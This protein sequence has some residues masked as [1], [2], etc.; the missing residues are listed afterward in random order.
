[1]ALTWSFTGEVY[2]ASGTAGNDVVTLATDGNP[3]TNQNVLKLLDGN[4]YAMLDWG[5]DFGNGGA[6]NDT[7]YGGWGNDQLIG[8]AD[9]DVLYGDDG[10]DKLF[11][12]DG[13]DA[14]YGGAGNDLLDSELADND[15]DNL[16]GGNGHDT[17]VIRDTRDVITGEAGFGTASSR[18]VIELYAA[19]FNMNQSVDTQAV[20]ELR[21]INSSGAK[22]TGNMY[23]NTITGAAG[24]DDINGDAGNDRI[25]GGKGHDTLSGSLGDDEVRGEDGSDLINGNNGLDTLTGGTG[26]DAMYGGDQSDWMDGGLGSDS[27]FGGAGNDTMYGEKDQQPDSTGFDGFYGGSGHDKIYAGLGN[28]M[29]WGD[30]GNDVLDGGT[31]NDTLTG[32]TGDDSYYVDSAQDSVRE[33]ANEGYDI[34]YASVSKLDVGGIYDP[35]GSAIEAVIYTGPKVAVEFWGGSWGEVFSGIAAASAV[36]HGRGGNDDITGS[37]GNDS[38]YGDDGNDFIQGLQGS[39]Y[40]DGGSGND[41]LRGGTGNDYYIIN[42]GDTVTEDANGGYDTAKVWAKG[43]YSLAANVEAGVAWGDQI[44]L[45]QGNALDNTLTASGYSGM[46]LRGLD[47][48]DKLIGTEAWDNLEGGSGNDTL[49][50]NGGEDVLDGGTGAD[51]MQ[52]GAG[53][54]IYWVDNAGDKVV[55]S[56]FGNGVDTVRATTSSY[57]LAADVENLVYFGTTNFTGTGS[58]IANRIEGGRANDVLKGMGGNDVIVGHGGKDSVWGGAGADQFVFSNDNGTKND[59]RVMDF[60]GGVDKLVLDADAGWTVQYVDADTTSFVSATG[61]TVVVDGLDLGDLGNSLIFV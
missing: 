11:G 15:W 21:I 24:F 58:D 37:A 20:E 44:K 59:A 40:I 49:T 25:L 1:M 8:E 17:Y 38:L 34:I 53:N 13:A 18:D 5:D 60:Q 57:T 2:S 41:T 14:M 42:P 31:G 52:G 3:L 6:G 47:G 45:L 30:A 61:G 43:G 7:I 22:V 54:D 29:V 10:N 4:D 35:A 36:I 28:D 50:G 16:S 23:A 55:E 9:N 32:G 56:I 12:G 27:L 48:Q 46:T 39:D 51:L 26:G 33:N 19:S